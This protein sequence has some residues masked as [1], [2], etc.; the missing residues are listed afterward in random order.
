MAERLHS[1]R[2]FSVYCECSD[3]ACR[4]EIWLTLA[5][6]NGAKSRPN[7]IVIAPGHPLA[8]GEMILEETKRFVV[9]EA[10]TP[11]L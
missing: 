3:E 2:R 7:R 11:P 5:E 10:G 1:D 6:W 4:T 8:A 9:A